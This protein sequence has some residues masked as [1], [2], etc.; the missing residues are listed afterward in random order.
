MCAS[1]LEFLAEPLELP[2]YGCK[3]FRATDAWA[4]NHWIFCIYI[5]I[6]IYMHNAFNALEV[7]DSTRSRGGRE[8]RGGSGGEGESGERRERRGGGH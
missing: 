7:R 4:K 5:Y 2:R 6:Y 8:G 3:N 1:P